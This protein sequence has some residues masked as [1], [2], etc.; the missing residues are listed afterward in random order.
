MILKIEL[1]SQNQVI[2]LET[3]IFNGLINS[4]LL[5]KKIIVEDGN[6]LWRI[7]RKNFRRRSSIC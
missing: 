3:S 2:S 7:A 1:A 4:E 6:S 5:Q